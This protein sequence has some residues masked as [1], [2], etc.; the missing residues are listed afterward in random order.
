M[1]K[2]ILV[3]LIVSLIGLGTFVLAKGKPTP[4]P[5]TGITGKVIALD[6]GHGGTEVGAQYPAN[7]GSNALVYEKD[8]NLAVV[9]ALKAEL[10]K[11]GASVVLTRTCD[12]TLTLKQ[13]ADLATQECKAL[14]GK[15]CDVF[16][17][18]HH[19]GNTDATHDGT[20]VIYNNGGNNKSFATSMHNALVS[21]LSGLTDEGYLSG[22]YG[23]T[24]FGKFTQ[25]LTEAYYITN[26]A[27][28]SYYLSGTPT[29]VCTNSDG[30]S[31]SV[32]MSPRIQQEADAQYAGLVSYFSK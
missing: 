29:I 2:I 24:I 12:E 8:V 25:A 15:D 28:A 13:R 26:D 21:G 3:V 22:G 1:K 14:S 32:N 27:E 30:S 23:S 11:A 18:I 17:A 20:L 19:N 16:L 4:P 5:S 31:Y 7:S 6:A 9:Y 10:E